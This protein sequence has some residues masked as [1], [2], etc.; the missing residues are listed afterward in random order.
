MGNRAAGRRI[1]FGVYVGFAVV[2]AFLAPRFTGIFIF[3]GFIILARIGNLNKIEAVYDGYRPEEDKN[4]SR[5][6]HLYSQQ[7]SMKKDPSH[8]T[9][10]DKPLSEAER[11]VLYG[12]NNN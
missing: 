11:N 4:S 7:Y 3:V 2:I 12:R 8:F 6:Q 1:L 9:V 5:S 10:E